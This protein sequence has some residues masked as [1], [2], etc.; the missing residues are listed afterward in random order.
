MSSAERDR[1][2]SIDSVAQTALLSHCVTRIVADALLTA[3][4]AYA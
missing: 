4:D 1:I 3:V 2:C